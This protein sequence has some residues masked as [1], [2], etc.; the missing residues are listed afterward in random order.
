MHEAVGEVLAVVN[1]DGEPSE[2]H[3]TL[4]RVG[5]CAAR[6]CVGAHAI[7]THASAIASRTGPDCSCA[8]HQRAS[9][10]VCSG[11]RAVQLL[12][13]DRAILFNTST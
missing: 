10:W 2:A 12:P 6:D 1:A 3:A 11:Y 7:L 13:A 5:P 4:K 8:A 9:F